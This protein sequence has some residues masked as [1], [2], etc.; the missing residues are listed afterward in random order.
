ME[1]HSN[2]TFDSALE[3]KAAGLVAASA[4][5]DILDLGAGFVEGNLVIDLSACEIATGDEI[6][7]VSLEAS[8]VAAMTSGSVCLAKKVFGN[9]V[10]PMDAALSA[11]GRY[12]IPFRN[13][14][15]GTLFRYV[16][17]STLVAGT[18]ATGINFSAFIAKAD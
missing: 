10:V 9:L 1:R 15:N 5:G 12:V 6:Y 17:L 14:E 4:D 3:M 11:A 2:F 16:R 13:E 7:T 18:V 8:N